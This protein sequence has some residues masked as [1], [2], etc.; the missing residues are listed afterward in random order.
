MREG[1]D[2]DNDMTPIVLVESK[3]NQIFAFVDKTPAMNTLNTNVTYDYSSDFLLD[4]SSHRGLGFNSKSEATPSGTKLEEGER[5]CFDTSPDEKGDTYEC[6]TF[7]VGNE[8]AE[9]LLDE[10]SFL[11]KNTILFR[12][13]SL[14]LANDFF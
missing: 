11:E 3:E 12:G 4:V 7:K 6:S 8:I 1:N 14:S 5:S 13:F 9:Y 2:G 10:D